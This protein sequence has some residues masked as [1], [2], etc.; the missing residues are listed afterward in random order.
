MYK[1]NQSLS[2]LYHICA[3]NIFLSAE[4]VDIPLELVAMVILHLWDLQLNEPVSINCTYNL[5]FVSIVISCMNRHME[6]PWHRW[7]HKRLITSTSKS[8]TLVISIYWVVCYTTLTYDSFLCFGHITQHYATCHKDYENLLVI[9]VTVFPHL[10]LYLFLYFDFLCF[11]IFFFTINWY[12]LSFHYGAVPSWCYYKY[13]KNLAKK[14][15]C[16]LTFVYY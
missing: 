1:C 11:S 7:F 15:L 4:N 10:L 3:K 14:M 13:M 9:M 5:W 16:K 12:K 2:A 8:D 6:W